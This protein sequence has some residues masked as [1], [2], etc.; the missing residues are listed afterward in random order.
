MTKTARK[1]ALGVSVVLALVAL[2]ADCFA[3]SPSPDSV[4]KPLAFHATTRETLRVGMSTALSGPTAELGLNVRDGVR[5]AFVESQ[6]KQ[7][8]AGK[9]LELITLD[10]GY[11]P[12]RTTPNMHQ[13]T[14]D[15]RVLAVVGNVGTPTATT[16]IPIAKRLSTPFF[17]AITG[18]SALRGETASELVINNRASYAQETAAM[19]NALLSQGIKAEEIGFFT[20]NDSYGD[21]GFFG[22][23]AALRSHQPVK[24]SA[25]PHGRYRRNT[26]QVED[27][28]ADGMMQQP[29]PKAVIMVGTYAPCSKLIRL[30][31]EN[32]FNPQFLAVSFVGSEAFQRSLGDLADGVIVTQV[33]PHY[34]SDLPLV[35][36][37]SDEVWPVMLGIGTSRPIDWKSVPRD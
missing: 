37:A 13:L 10:D 33:V 19:V 24:Q 6:T 27:G 25:V 18:A 20:Q 22:G 8:I 21:D 17:G 14:S 5:A 11:E 30:A 23:L 7:T 12:E 35:Q 4:Q 15:L 34:S 1:I 3:T 28:L 2:A 26:L 16:A 31:R 32:N 36:Q 29:L 9:V